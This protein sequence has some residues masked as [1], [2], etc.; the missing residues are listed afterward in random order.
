SPEPGG[1]ADQ[2]MRDT[3]SQRIALAGRGRLEGR[4]RHVPL[5]KVD[6][7]A[8]LGREMSEL[9]HEQALAGAGKPAKEDHPRG[10]ERL[11][12]LRERS[13]AVNHDPIPPPPHPAAP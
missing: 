5:E 7:P 12:P 3:A 6:A 2:R 9:M 4:T 8:D 1:L 13:V 10:R 11:E